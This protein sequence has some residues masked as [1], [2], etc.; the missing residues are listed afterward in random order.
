MIVGIFEVMQSL[1]CGLVLLFNQFLA[2]TCSI[3]YYFLSSS[4]SL[5]N[6]CGSALI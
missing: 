5:H 6:A 3:F 4:H 2:K 1:S